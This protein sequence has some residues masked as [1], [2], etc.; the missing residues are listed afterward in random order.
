MSRGPAPSSTSTQKVTD[1]PASRSRRCRSTCGVVPC[2]IRLDTDG[3][4]FNDCADN[5][6]DSWNSLEDDGDGDGDGV[7]DWCDPCVVDPYKAGSGVCGCGVLDVDS[8]GDGAP[9]CVDECPGG[10]DFIDSDGDE[11][12]DGFNDC[13]AAPD[14]QAD[15]DADGVGDARD[16]CPADGGKS[17]PGVCGCG[18]SDIDSAGD[19]VSDC[20]DVCAAGDDALDRDSDGVADACDTCLATADSDQIDSAGDGV[21]DACDRCAGEDDLEDGDADGA[22]DGCA[23]GMCADPLAIVG[24]GHFSGEL[25]AD[26]PS[27]LAATC[28]G[29]FGA[30]TVF[31]W[32]PDV[33]GPH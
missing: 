9:D 23:A 7:G 3:A 15:S 2:S 4:G 18:S 31:V 19:G 16:A 11:L 20:V 12:P 33:S 13:A 32:T 22:S 17:L 26:A 27:R 5:C 21:G 29:D 8:D 30:E 28:G 1:L 25:S 6:P 10:S 24:I 14:D